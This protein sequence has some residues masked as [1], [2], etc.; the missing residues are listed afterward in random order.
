MKNLLEKVQENEP[1]GRK[2]QK[3]K[4][5]RKSNGTRQKNKRGDNKVESN[6]SPEIPDRVEASDIPGHPSGAEVCRTFRFQWY[7]GKLV[8]RLI[9][10]KRKMLPWHNSTMIR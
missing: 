8:A 10:W 3:E 6:D 7:A 9:V 2:E 4:K 1:A 5:D